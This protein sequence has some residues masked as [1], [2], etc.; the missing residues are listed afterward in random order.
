MSEELETKVFTINNVE[1]H[2]TALATLPAFRLSNKLIPVIG[3]GIESL[4]KGIKAGDL[5]TA[6]VDPSKIELSK[7][8]SELKPELFAELL[9]AFRAQTS[10]RL[11]SG[12][13]V[14]LSN[15]LFFNKTF[16]R[17]MKLL[18]SCLIEFCKF[19]FSDFLDGFSE[20]AS[21]LKAIQASA[22][23]TPLSGSS[24]ES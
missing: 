4:A 8:V 17:K 9:S 21:K 22:S 20:I 19:N 2:T 24:T 15:E 16:N 11:D 5:K 1:F 18:Y 13:L 10:T 12:D 6:E 7:L 23:P 3:A 14:P